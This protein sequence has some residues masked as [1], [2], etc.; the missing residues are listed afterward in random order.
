MLLLVN[1]YDKADLEINEYRKGQLTL[2]AG[3]DAIQVSTVR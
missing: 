1:R 2:R 3:C